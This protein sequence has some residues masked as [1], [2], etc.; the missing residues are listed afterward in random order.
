[1]HHPLPPDVPTLRV[2]HN[3]AIKEEMFLRFLIV[4]VDD[5]DLVLLRER[6]EPFERRPANGLAQIEKLVP[7]RQPREELQDRHLGQHNDP[8]T[9]LR[10]LLDEALD[11]VP[12]RLNV[13][14]SMY[15]CNGD[16]HASQCQAARANCQTFDG[17]FV[18]AAACSVAVQGTN[19]DKYVQPPPEAAAT[20]R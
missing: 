11:L 2:H 10:S 19:D 7:M 1:M 20:A 15:L 17:L 5:V 14:R 8:G 12:V 18:S 13:R 6:C 3:A 9:T 4:V 16:L